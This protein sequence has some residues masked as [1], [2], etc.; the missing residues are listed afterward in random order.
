M[1]SGHA[2]L[3][4]SPPYAT[5]NQ[6]TRHI[7]CIIYHAQ[8]QVLYMFYHHFCPPHISISCK[9]ASSMQE[10]TINVCH[11]GY[12]L[13][14][15]YCVCNHGHP[16]IFRCDGSNRYFYIRVGQQ[17]QPCTLST[18]VKCHCWINWCVISYSK[19][20]CIDTRTHYFIF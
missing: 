8:L 9:D 17:Q 10:F 1:G 14:G 7:I 3:P 16:D 4:H 20:S 18:W 15:E 11:P 19:P 13:D 12:E 2:L 6:I 5:S